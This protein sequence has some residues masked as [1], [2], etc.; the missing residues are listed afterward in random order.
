MSKSDEDMIREYE[1]NNLIK[2]QKKKKLFVESKRLD[3]SPKSDAKNDRLTATTNELNN[4]Y[5][6]QNIKRVAEKVSKTDFK[7]KR[8]LFLR[9]YTDRFLSFDIYNRYDAEFEIILIHPINETNLH[10]TVESFYQSLRSIVLIGQTLPEDILRQDCQDLVESEVYQY[11]I[12]ILKDAKTTVKT[13]NGLVRKFKPISKK[14]TYYGMF[15]RILIFLIEDFLNWRKSSEYLFDDIFDVDDQI[16]IIKNTIHNLEQLDSAILNKE[17][18]KSFGVTEEEFHDTFLEE[19][20]DVLL[21]AIFQ[22][23]EDNYIDFHNILRYDFLVENFQAYDDGEKDVT[24]ISDKTS[25][26]SINKLTLYYF[27]QGAID[28]LTVLVLIQLLFK[29]EEN[30]N[31]NKDREIILRFLEELKVNSNIEFIEYLQFLV[32]DHKYKNIIFIVYISRTISLS[33]TDAFKLSQALGIGNKKTF[34]KHFD[35]LFSHFFPNYT[36][37]K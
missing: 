33:R 5:R 13:L 23:A 18:L 12:N 9:T 19:K 25:L 7:L 28:G 29:R 36:Y 21:S 16:R 1:E 15:A 11:I 27:S 37:I 4:K 31:H 8:N 34:D 24:L 26:K 22:K 30:S 10:Q 35:T 32:L 20:I 14:E 2:K 6:K 3:N 17:L